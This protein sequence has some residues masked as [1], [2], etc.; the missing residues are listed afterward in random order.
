[1]DV[2]AFA[3]AWMFRLH[4]G[5]APVD[6]CASAPASGLGWGWTLSAYGELPLVATEIG[7]AMAA[8]LG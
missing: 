8:A 1:M 6:I 7:T 2:L 5:T 3:S 4:D